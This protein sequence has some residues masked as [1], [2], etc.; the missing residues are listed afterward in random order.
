MIQSG[1][2]VW[3][4]VPGLARRTKYKKAVRESTDSLLPAHF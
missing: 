1:I 2:H 4:V 3:L